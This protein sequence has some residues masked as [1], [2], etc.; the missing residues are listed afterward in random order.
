[1]TI[2]KGFVNIA[3]I[4]QLNHCQKPICRQRLTTEYDSIKA[5][6]IG[7]NNVNKKVGK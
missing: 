2:G 6:R 5:A 7:Q 1:M 4:T 3:D